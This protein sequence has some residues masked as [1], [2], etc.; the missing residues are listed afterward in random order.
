MDT[1]RAHEDRLQACICLHRIPFALLLVQAAGV[2]PLGR[3]SKGLPPTPSTTPTTPPTLTLLPS[4]RYSSAWL[5]SLGGFCGRT[6]QRGST[7]LVDAFGSRAIQVGEASACATVVCERFAPPLLPPALEV[8]TGCACRK[9]AITR[10]SDWH[11]QGPLQL[12]LGICAVALLACSS[13]GAAL[14]VWTPVRAMAPKAR[15]AAGS[16]LVGREGA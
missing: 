6:Q 4:R 5:G 8:L 14:P 10:G 1:Q 16:I 13:A 11:W 9:R 12:Q 7:S 3:L 15:T 2:G